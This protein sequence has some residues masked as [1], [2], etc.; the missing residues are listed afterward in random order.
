MISGFLEKAEASM[1]VLVST[2]EEC[3]RERL[4]EESLNSFVEC[5]REFATTRGWS[6]G[7]SFGGMTW[8]KSAAEVG[9]GMQMDVCCKQ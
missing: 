7:W 5:L 9:C 8:E 6:F 2:C 4:I 1:F 3:L